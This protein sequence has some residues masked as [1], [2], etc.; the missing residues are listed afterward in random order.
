MDVD[1]ASEFRYRNPVI[2]DKALVIVLSQSGETLDTLE[3]MKEAKRH[4]AR[5]VA[6]SNVVGSSIARE[7]DHVIYTWAGP[8]IAVASTKA[9]T[10]QMVIL[11]LMAI[12]FAY[13]FGK[14]TKDEAIKD[15]KKLYEVEQSIQKMLEYN[16]K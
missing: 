14:I 2:D 7:A 16:E 1:I 10:T 9:Y 3:A 13:K 8:E 6:I 15:I 4:G 5:V 11:N 12:D